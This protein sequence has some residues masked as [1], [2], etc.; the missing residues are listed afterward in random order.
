MTA[1]IFIS[2]A[3]WASFQRP[4]RDTPYWRTLKA[5]G[6]LNEKYPGGI[7]A[8]RALLEAEGVPFRPAGTVDLDACL[9]AP[10]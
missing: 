10:A 4:E 1:G 7:P 2:M 8:Q 6:E 5:G 9:W 3:A